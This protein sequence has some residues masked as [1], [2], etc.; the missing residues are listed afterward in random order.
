MPCCRRTM[1]VI[2]PKTH[3]VQVLN[4]N[5][6]FRTVFIIFQHSVEEGA[7]CTSCC[8]TGCGQPVCHYLLQ[9]HH[10]GVVQIDCSVRAAG[11]L[12]KNISCGF[13]RN[14]FGFDTVRVLTYLQIWWLFAVCRSSLTTRVLPG[15]RIPPAQSP[16][17]KSGSG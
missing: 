12:R 14:G 13:D 17:L 7:Y 11:R 9:F 5:P 3:C 16:R 6:S 4:G 15:H 2:G 1:R 10:R 8:N